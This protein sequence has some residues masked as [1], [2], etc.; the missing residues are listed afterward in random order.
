MRR[1]RAAGAG[2]R[3]LR[4]LMVMLLGF[5]GV[6]IDI[7]RQVAERRHVQTAADAGA[8]AACRAL[9][10][11]DDRC[12]RRDGRA[13]GRP[14]RTSQDSPAGA[15]A[16]IDSPPT[17]EDDDG[18]GVIDADELVSGI[19]V[20]GTTVRVAI[21][22]TVDTTLA[23]VVGIPTLETGA[24]AR[25]DL[26]GGPAVPIVARRY[27]NPPGPGQRLR[28]PP[29]DRR[30]ERVGRGRHGRTRAA[31]T[32][33]LPAS[34]AAPG[35]AVHDL[36]TDSKAH[37]D[38]SFRGFVA[39]DVRNF[40]G[41]DTP[42][43]LQRRHER[44]EPEHPQGHGGRVPRHRLSRARH[45]RRSRRRRPATPRSPSSPATAPRSSSSQF[46]DK[47]RD[48]DRLMLAVYDGTVMEIPDF[49]ISPPVEIACRRPRPRR[50]TARRSRC[51]ETRSSTAP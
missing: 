25:C 30:D 27:A 36:R 23:R 46:D 17:Y 42:R 44:H 35:P 10:A 18:S 14:S 6:A 34:E 15:T 3:D 19:V 16:T 47:F 2:A 50:S 7:G 13:A 48:G 4:V 12:G 1:R 5:A 21:S 8:L 43:L 26:Q 31:T 39:L 49:A 22:S 28:R 40:E 38:S 45:S 37:N 24:R 32:S 33:G 11:G 29:R 20:A 41:T 51:R 9:I